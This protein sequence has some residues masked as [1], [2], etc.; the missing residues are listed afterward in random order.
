MAKKSKASNLDINELKE[1]YIKLL[2]LKSQSDCGCDKYNTESTD[3]SFPVICFVLGGIFLIGLFLLVWTGVGYNLV[4]LL[5]IIGDILG[6]PW[7]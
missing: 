4:M 3:W 2:E 7:A 5:Q 1:L 6:C